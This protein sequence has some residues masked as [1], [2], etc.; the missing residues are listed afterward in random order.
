M[1]LLSADTSPTAE[2][3]QLA[4]LRAMPGWKKLALAMELNAARDHL[5]RQGLRRR[6]P[7]AS[8][9][10]IQRRLLDLK[11]GPERAAI[12]YGPLAAWIEP[13]A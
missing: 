7:S 9:R 2:A 1:A 10:E 4:I 12:V 6:Y 8:D 3:H 11:L 13:P 5:A